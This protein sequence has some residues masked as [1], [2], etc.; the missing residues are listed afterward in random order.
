[1]SHRIP[2]S[3]PL[4]CANARVKRDAR[5]SEWGGG[6]GVGLRESRTSLRALEAG[7]RRSARL[8]TVGES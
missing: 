1:M 7:G 6:Q 2:L 3:E 5:A 8:A 4:F